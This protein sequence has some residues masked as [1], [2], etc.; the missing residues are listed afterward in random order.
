MEQD[1]EELAAGTAPRQSESDRPPVG[2]PLVV[3]RRN[4]AARPAGADG[5]AAEPAAAPAAR[6]DDAPDASAAR[7]AELDGRV[8][9]VTAAAGEL[10]G[11]LAAAL[12]DRGARVLL[13]DHD[14]GGLVDAVD[15][16]AHGRAVPVWCD[17][18]SDAAVASACEFVARSA[19]VDVVVHVGEAAQPDAEVRPDLEDRYGSTV[20]GPLALVGGLA[21]SLAPSAQVLLVGPPVPADAD[22]LDR[23]APELVREHLPV[24]DDVRVAR[25]ECGPGL[26][27]GLFAGAVVD[28]LA[29]D[30]VALR[31]LALDAVVDEV[32]TTLPDALDGL[33][34]IG[35]PLR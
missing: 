20:R 2:E 27:P 35:D 6:T 21:P 1:P 30:D 29:R 32:P 8:A 16:L 25:A 3:S 7:R 24:A 33:G 23:V 13:V 26:A 9:L 11:A 12:V 22:A 14:L 34:G 10:G 19:T 4:P 28:L 5:A 31:Q 18:T 17:L 15:A